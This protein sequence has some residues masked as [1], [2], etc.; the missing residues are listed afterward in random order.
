MGS[1]GNHLEVQ[2]AAAIQQDTAIDPNDVDQT[3]SR[4]LANLSVQ[5][6][7]AIME[8]VHGV[9]CLAVEETP[10]LLHSSLRRLSEELNLIVV[11]PAFNRCQELARTSPR[12]SYVNS[13]EFRLRFLRCDLF[14]TK[15]AA[16]RLVNYL[17]TL[18]LLFDGK[19]E[20]LMRPIRLSD[21]SKTE[22]AVMKVGNFQLLPYRDRSGRRVLTLHINLSLALEFVMTVSRFCVL[23]ERKYPLSVRMRISLVGINSQV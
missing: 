2:A 17:D 11:K 16:I 7:E 18:M 23:H 5:G 12:T 15:K 8:E 22:M 19:E 13:P 3:L 20:L 10:E 21:F 9:R 14:D 6:R 4:E 1:K